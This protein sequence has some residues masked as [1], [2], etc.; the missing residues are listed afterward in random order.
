MDKHSMPTTGISLERAT[1]RSLEPTQGYRFQ[2]DTRMASFATRPKGDQADHAA[3][4]ARGY[5]P[6]VVDTPDQDG[7]SVVRRHPAGRTRERGLPHRDGRLGSTSR[8]DLL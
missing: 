2:H 6:P 1:D 8:G 7:V 5:Q 4:A 3:I